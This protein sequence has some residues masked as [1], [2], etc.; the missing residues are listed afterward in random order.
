MRISPITYN[1]KNKKTLGSKPQEPLYSAKKSPQTSSMPAFTG[2]T[3]QCLKSTLFEKSRYDAWLAKL[4]EH[5]KAFGEK[6]IPY[7]LGIELTDKIYHK[8]IHTH[9]DYSNSIATL[10]DKI[11]EQNFEFS[12]TSNWVVA[13]QNLNAVNYILEHLDKIFYATKILGGAALA[14]A[15][16]MKQKRFEVLLNDIN[17]YVSF[18]P[19][20]HIE[21]LMEMTNPSLTQ[22]YKYLDNKKST[23]QSD[24]RN[25][26]DFM[27]LH[28]KNKEL[29]S[30]LEQKI[31][32]KKLNSDTS[33]IINLY[34]EIK[35]IRQQEKLAKSANLL[36]LE[37]EMTETKAEIN[38]LLSK[39]IKD[40]Q[41][42][43]ELFYLYKSFSDR[44]E[45][46]ELNKIFTND[47]S[48]KNLEL[49]A[50]LFNKL[51]TAYNLNPKEQELVKALDLQ[52]SPYL[53]RLF[54]AAPEKETFAYGIEIH[55]NYLQKGFYNNF[56]KLLSTVTQH[57]AFN[58][59]Q[60]K[61][62]TLEA[63]LETIFN[64][65]PHNKKTKSLFEE[66]NLDFE[67]W[68]THNP[69]RDFIRIDDRTI[70]RKVNMNKLK[71]SLF[72]GNQ[73]CCCTAVGSGSRAASAANY[74][75]NK[76]VQAIELLVD[77]TI[78]GNT[79]CYIA[80]VD[81]KSYPRMHA[82]SW[83]EIEIKENS[84]KNKLALILDNM[85]ILPPYN[86]DEKYLDA[87]I[88][89]ANKLI[90]DING[91][92]D[93]AIYSGHRNSC[94]MAY[95]TKENIERMFILGDSTNFPVSL[96]SISNLAIVNEE[97]SP[98]RIYYGKFYCIKR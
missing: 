37:K 8:Y 79:M 36:E 56:K 22:Y 24:I 17:R 70:I 19:A 54:Q 4:P 6:I 48:K 76:F 28:K 41:R 66:K 85:E 58:K 40:P 73:A 44:D 83:G 21:L 98:E 63:T 59:L 25:H 86:K 90:K 84:K 39:S 3:P 26:K 51:T 65:L 50:F 81:A 46:Q 47:T 29:I 11:L 16:N 92:P 53:A 75:I 5:N 87:F 67:T 32:E 20:S 82:T 9:I 96:D 88:L 31:K 74:P 89:Y 95:Y 61:E 33:V 78:I 60:A 30:N 34:K 71:T 55:T 35:N 1:H 64:E 94:S 68:S 18:S 91:Q 49:Q 38:K 13:N 14:Y 27:N 10:R 45:L 42:K 80:T 2:L 52:N 72:L 23:I 43:I 62:I 77:N 57:T 97:I 7:N 69:E 93:M 15:L 12:L